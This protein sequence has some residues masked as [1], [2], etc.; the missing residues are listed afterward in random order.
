MNQLN[1]LPKIIFYNAD[2][3]LNH[4][5]Q[6]LIQCFQFNTDGII[7]KLQQGP[8]WWF[9]DTYQGNKNQLIHLAEQGSLLNFVGMTT[10]SRSFTSYIRHDYFRKI[11]AEI[12]FDWL[13]KDIIPNDEQALRNAFK[14]I[15]YQNALDYFK[16]E[17]L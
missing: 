3:N 4:I 14:R 9:L 13:S 16:L 8:A 1:S 17:K 15:C 11:L 7:A 12:I 5:L 6:T 2:P 10:D